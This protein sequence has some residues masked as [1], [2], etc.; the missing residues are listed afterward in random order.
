MSDTGDIWSCQFLLINEMFKKIRT[1]GGTKRTLSTYSTETSFL[2]PSYVDSSLFVIPNM[3]ILH[4]F[5]FEEHMQIFAK[6]Y[7]IVEDNQ[8]VCAWTKNSIFHIS[9]PCPF[10][11][12]NWQPSTSQKHTEFSPCST[13]MYLLNNI[14]PWDDMHYLNVVN[15]NV[16]LL[17]GRWNCLTAL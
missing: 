12:M 9:T 15:F 14:D 4:F 16:T 8:S 17:F 13:N 3:N 6:P 10:G 2:N 11:L 5:M 1:G 7:G